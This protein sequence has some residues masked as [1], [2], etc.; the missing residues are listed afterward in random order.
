MPFGAVQRKFLHGLSHLRQFNAAGHTG[1]DFYDTGKRGRFF[2]D[3]ARNALD[4]YGPLFYCLVD[5]LRPYLGS[6]GK[7]L[8]QIATH[9][10]VDR[11]LEKTFK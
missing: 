7:L 11:H 5:M 10:D 1:A 3:N 8:F 6:Y 9:D 4:P 2:S